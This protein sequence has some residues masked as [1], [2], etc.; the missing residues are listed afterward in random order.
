VTQHKLHVT[1]SNLIKFT[2]VSDDTKNLTLR[3]NDFTTAA[4]SP[5]T[6]VRFYQ[7]AQRHIHDDR[8]F[9]CH[10]R[11]NPNSQKPVTQ[12]HIVPCSHQ[13]RN[14]IVSE[15]YAAG[16]VSREDG[17]SGTFSREETRMDQTFPRSYLQLMLLQTTH[18]TTQAGMSLTLYLYSVS[19]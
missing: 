18:F 15:G 6:S 8:K 5:E 1:P 13:A 4:E 2:D 17:R 3:V 16:S 12:R 10:H 7:T 14:A 9:H 19:L 11:E